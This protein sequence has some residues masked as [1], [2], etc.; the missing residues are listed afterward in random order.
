M[1]GYTTEKLEDLKPAVVHLDDVEADAVKPEAV[2]VDEK[3]S[4]W[5][6]IKKFPMAV[7]WCCYMLFICIMWGY[8]GLAGSIVLSIPRFRQD[9]GYL[10]N[11]QYV[12]S[13]DWQLGFTSA[14]LVGLMFG[15][16]V[17]GYMTERFGQK[18]C[19]TAAYALT[20][21]GVFA[22]WYSP[23]DMPLFFGGKLLTGIPL[24]VFLTV[25]PIYTS[26]VAPPAL[27][28]AMVA[29]VN[30]SI[31]IGQLIGYGVMR[32]VQSIDG[33]NSYR[34]MYA[35]QWGF[36]GVGLALIFFL[37][38]S[39]I[40]LV[41]RGK[42]DQARESIRKLYTAEVDLETK[43]AEIKAVLSHDAEQQNQSGSYR[44]CFNSKNRLRTAIALS[45]FFFQASSGVAWVVGY[46][47]YFM[48]LSG[49]QGLE[50]FDATVGIAG[51]MAVGSMV[52]WVTVEKLGRRRTIFFG[53]LTCT[54]SLLLIAILALFVDRGKPV[55][56]TQV[57]FMALWAF[58]YQASIGSVGFTLI[59][60]VPTSHLRGV[61]QSMAT[62]MNGLSNAVW[63]L[64][65]PYMV[66]PDQANM[67]GKVAFIFF[68]LLLLGDIFVFFY[69]PE[70]KG[71]SFE[72][73]DAL[74]E[75]GVPPR[76]FE[77]TKLD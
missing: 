14:S 10:Y 48:Q 28:G 32:E 65:L 64:A 75:R 57:A 29:A 33:P 13:A 19:I 70:T 52:S 44:E 7:A 3:I 53:M 31:V 68:G 55:V 12:V 49:M 43:M 25:A 54:A 66:N 37:P 72:E 61:T 18:I 26:E 27:R 71:R 47:G 46:M 59:A 41:A 16:A 62:M 67:G 6:S 22:Q 5:Q 76:K 35:V 58:M 69:Y 8:D 42:E 45:V 1:A 74:F 17:T 50:V 38:E 2:K 39:P 34:I 40:R 9:Y 4:A 77:T 20:I 73:I 21:G 30:F 23:G 24:G 56:L 60:E 51:A 15:G 63:A 11:G 36:A